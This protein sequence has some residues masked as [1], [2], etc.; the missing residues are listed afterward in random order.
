MT[1]TRIY[2]EIPGLVE[3]LGNKSFHA[4]ANITG[5]GISG[6]LPRVIPNDMICEISK[7]SLPTPKWMSDFVKESNSTFEDVEHVFNFGAGMIAVIAGKN[8][9][10]F[11]KAAK[12]ASLRVNEIGTVRGGGT[13][14]AVVRYV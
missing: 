9:Q 8:G 3:T 12:K 5:G 13:G 2:R 4:L 6:N 7:K 14:E 10:D 1:P 11:E